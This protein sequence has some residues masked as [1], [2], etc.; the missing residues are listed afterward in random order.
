MS[1]Y[2]CKKNDKLRI[3]SSL[4]SPLNSP[5]D[6]VCSLWDGRHPEQITPSSFDAVILAVMDTGLPLT[7]LTLPE[8]LQ[9][10][11]RPTWLP[12]GFLSFYSYRA[13]RKGENMV[14]QVTRSPHALLSVIIHIVRVERTGLIFQRP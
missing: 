10:R 5:C 3:L 7:L 9:S 11:L 14:L 6:C 8:Y 13:A 12:G 4:L 2:W 1:Q